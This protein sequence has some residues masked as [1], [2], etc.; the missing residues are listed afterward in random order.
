MVNPG[1]LGRAAEARRRPSPMMWGDMVVLDKVPH[2]EEAL[3]CQLT[4]DL[5]TMSEARAGCAAAS[6]TWRQAGT[7]IC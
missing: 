6:I 1:Q 4:E 7:V 2:Q 5:R 3:D